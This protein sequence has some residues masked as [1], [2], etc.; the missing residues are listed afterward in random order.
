MSENQTVDEFV[1]TYTAALLARDAEAIAGHYA[2]PALV[3]FPG[4]RIAVSDAGQTAAFFRS[5]VGQYDGVT[6]AESHVDVVAETGHSLWLD[7]TWTYDE[8]GGERNMYQL[9]D[10]GDGWR[11]AVLTP[12]AE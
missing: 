8:G 7:I 5:A 9:V 11:I 12:L 1:R 6:R 4:Q 3:E 2:V 10:T